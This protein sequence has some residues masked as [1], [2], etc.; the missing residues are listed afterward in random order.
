MC[1]VTEHFGVRSQFSHAE[2]NYVKIADISVSN[3]VDFNMDCLTQKSN[4]KNIATA[5]HRLLNMLQN[6][7]TLSSSSEN[8]E[9]VI[10]AEIIKK[11]LAP[12]SQETLVE[13]KYSICANNNIKTQCLGM[14]LFNTWHGKPDGRLRGSVCEEIVVSLVDDDDDENSDGG[15]LTIDGKRCFS[16]KGMPQ[17]MSQLIATNVVSSFVEKNLHKDLNSMVP[18]LMMNGSW[19]VIC[20]YDCV[21]DY[22]LLSRRID[23]YEET[24]HLS[25]STLLFIW[26]FINHR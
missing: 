8:V 14:G 20:L 24:G 19:V 7:P 3:L 1:Q 18:S 4:D 10:F 5:A 26:L 16:A 13:S 2:I 23:L 15:T 6:L 22:L 11:I 25:R 21:R 9:K 17:F 12:L